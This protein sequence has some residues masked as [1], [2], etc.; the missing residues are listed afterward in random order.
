MD[1]APVQGF[2]V[3]RTRSSDQAVTSSAGTSEAVPLRYLRLRAAT[4]ALGPVDSTFD[5]NLRPLVRSVSPGVPSA[6]TGL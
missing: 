5:Q 4:A 1:A 6:R 2:V 3:E